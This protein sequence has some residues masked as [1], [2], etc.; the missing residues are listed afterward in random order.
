MTS[1]SQTPKLEQ[2]EPPGSDGVA[3]TLG[4]TDEVCRRVAP[5]RREMASLLDGSTALSSGSLPNTLSWESPFCSGVQGAEPHVGVSRKNIFEVP[6][7][8][9]GAPSALAVEPSA[10]GSLDTLRSSQSRKANSDATSD[11]RP[12]KERALDELRVVGLYADASRWESCGIKEPYYCGGCGNRRLVAVRCDLK[13][14]PDCA[15]RRAAKLRAAWLRAAHRVPKRRGYRWALLTLTLV[16]SGDVRADYARI[17]KCWQRMT[18][19]LRRKHDGIGGFRSVE[20]GDDGNV[21]IHALSYLP[22]IEQA[23]L[24]DEW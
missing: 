7:A 24:S 15:R 2:V 16:K 8:P 21:H 6:S 22:F 23:T 13:I 20:V 5:S 12:E 10:L 1:L 14:C 3:P 18:Q 17:V 11:T 19:K 4:T 9:L